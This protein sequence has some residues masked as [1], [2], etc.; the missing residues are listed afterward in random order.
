MIYFQ[1]RIYR[2]DLRNNPNHLFVFGDNLARVGLGGQAK[3]MRGEPNA[4]GVATKRSPYEY[5][6]DKD[7]DEW[8]NKEFHTIR[9][10][11][12]LAECGTMLVYPSDGIGTG[13]AKLDQTAP[14]IYE[15]IKKMEDY[16]KSLV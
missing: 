7:Y 9:Y 12:D 13:L 14:K 4:I 10:I 15:R 11:E 1:H 8:F 3:E 6:Y 2:S 5:L 16:L